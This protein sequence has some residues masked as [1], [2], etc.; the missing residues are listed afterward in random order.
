[1]ETQTRNPHLSDEELFRLAM[2]AAGEPEALPP[3]LLQCS[4]CGRA[5]QEWKRAARDLAEQDEAAL[6]RRPA[7]DWL[8]AEDATLAAIRKSGR[9]GSRRRALPWALALAASLL[10][11]VLLVTDRTRQAEPFLLED[12]AEELSAEDS[13]DDRLLREVAVLARGD[14]AGDVW[15]SLAPLPETDGLAEVADE[16]SL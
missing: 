13:A 9:P 16:E 11:A 6:A 4:A 12:A 2:P 3:H 1:M 15:N 10:I 5:L 14:E 7:E 8:A